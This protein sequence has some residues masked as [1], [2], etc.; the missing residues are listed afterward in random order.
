MT[1]LRGTQSTCLR[2]MIHSIPLNYSHFAGVVAL[3]SFGLISIICI[4]DRRKYPWYR[5]KTVEGDL[6]KISIMTNPKMD[7]RWVELVSCT[8]SRS[9]LSFVHVQ[10]RINRKSQYSCLEQGSW[11]VKRAHDD[12][13]WLHSLT[14]KGHLP[15]THVLVCRMHRHS[16][17]GILVSTV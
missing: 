12:V 16:S 7:F 5:P 6:V 14:R 2:I 15:I 4:L 10:R 3:T 17:G 13:K 11:I 8:A 9:R 1:R